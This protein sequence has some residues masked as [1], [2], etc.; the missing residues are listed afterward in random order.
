MFKKAIPGIKKYSG[1][2]NFLFQLV[3]WKRTVVTVR[4]RQKM[5]VHIVFEQMKIVVL[6]E[7][8]NTQKK[9]YN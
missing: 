4:Q 9:I 3:L 7:D 1:T 6:G 5:V 8:D 2:P